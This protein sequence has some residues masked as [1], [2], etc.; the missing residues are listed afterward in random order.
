MDF[1]SILYTKDAGGIATI[2]LNRPDHNA[3]D[4]QIQG[5]WTLAVD[6]AE[7]DPAVK[8][9]IITAN[10]RHFCAGANPRDLDRRRRE[11]TETP[12]GAP[13]MPPGRGTSQ[14]RRMARF[15]K[16]YL[17]A[18]NGAAIGGGMDFASLCDIRIA[19][20]R[21]RFGMGYLRMGV[22]PGGGGC[23]LLPR[24][25][26][27]QQALR[28]IWTSE[29]IDA[30]EALRIGYVSAVVPHEDLLSATRELALLLAKGP[31]VA[32]RWA[33]KLAYEGLN[34]NMGE[35]LAAN[36]QAFALVQ[37]TADAKE[38]PRAYVEKREPNYQGR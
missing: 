9:L 36:E 7:A 30:Q 25:V 15:P 24:I 22:I 37:A 19:S 33:K 27:V 3:L 35:A 32:I 16:P 11:G 31:P 23:Y 26:G 21:A 38:G 12:A 20:E 14:A 29:I 8:V 5:E 28:L 13:D 34:Q 17:G 1:Q 10:G 4:G 2:T 6:D 18:I